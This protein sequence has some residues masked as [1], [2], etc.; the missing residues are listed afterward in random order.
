M[1]DF[2]FL[3]RF[4]ISFGILQYPFNQRR[5]HDNAI[6]KAALDNRR[7]ATADVGEFLKKSGL[8]GQQFPCCRPKKPLPPPPAAS[9]SASMGNI[10][11]LDGKTQSLRHVPMSASASLAEARTAS[12]GSWRPSTPA[13]GVVKEEFY[14]LVSLHAESLVLKKSFAQN[15]QNSKNVQNISKNTQKNP[16]SYTD[17]EIQRNSLS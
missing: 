13:V 10:P 7:T 14:N 2:N 12:T 17:I 1:S 5:D 15:P 9:S 6:L 8:Q 3:L 4:V 16:V 11:A